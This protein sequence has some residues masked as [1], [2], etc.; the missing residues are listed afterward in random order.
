VHP[1]Y[2]VLNSNAESPNALLG[3]KSG[4][5]IT[6]GGAATPP[7]NGPQTVSKI[8]ELAENNDH[9][10]SKLGVSY[11]AGAYTFSIYA[12]KAERKWLVIK[13]YDGIGG[14]Y[15]RFDLD[16]GSLGN[17]SAG[18]SAVITA[19]GDGWYLCSITATMPTTASGQYGVYIDIAN[20]VA[21]PGYLGDGSSGIL[22][23]GLNIVASAYRLPYVK[24]TTGAVSVASTA[25]TSAGN[26]LAIPLDARMTAALSAGGR[27]TA[28]ALCWM[29]AG[30][31]ELPAGVDTYISSFSVRNNVFDLLT[32]NKNGSDVFYHCR[33]YDGTTGAVY[34]DGGA[35]WSRGEIHLKV[36]QT[37]AL[38]TQFRVGNRRYTSAMVPINALTWGAWANYDGSMNPLTHLRFGYNSTV[39]LGFLQTQVWNK[40]CTDTEIL[41][42]MR[43]AS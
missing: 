25:A 35:T 2:T 4:T 23:A 30:S 17:V 3:Y 42:L 20:N 12:K 1:A 5:A 9:Q 28:A 15:A 19:E 14:L 34:P 13:F 39:P 37:N 26:G 24:T 8:Y 31:A 32:T 7:A 6:T 22:I 27:F 16:A 40:S 33:A 10:A 29:G 38:G 21:Q 43:Y 36:V 41:S 11:T 18:I